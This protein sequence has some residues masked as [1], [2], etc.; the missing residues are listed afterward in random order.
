MS[1][2]SETD[3]IQKL[4]K[5]VFVDQ[6]EFRLKL[7]EKN[8]PEL[9]EKTGDDATGDPMQDAEGEGLTDFQRKT[10]FLCR[11]LNLHLFVEVVIHEITHAINWSRDIEDGS[12]EETFTT[13]FSP[14]L[15]RF[16]LDNPRMHQW[17]NRAI[18]EIRKQ[19]V[20]VGSILD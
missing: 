1:D 3:L 2:V 18:R 13:R 15:V 10:I 8:A 12:S 4:P 11:D 6:Y 7:V 19:Q 16:L 17:L 20:N 9:A 5:R 14:G